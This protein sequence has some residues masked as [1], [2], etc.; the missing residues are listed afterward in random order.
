MS[1]RMRATFGSGGSYSAVAFGAVLITGITACRLGGPADELTINSA[2]GPTPDGGSSSGST[3]GGDSDGTT[4][5]SDTGSSSSG[6]TTGTSS[7]TGGVS[8]D[9][10]ADATLGDTGTHDPPDAGVI[11]PGPCVPPGAAP[12]VCDPVCNT[13]CSSLTRCDIADTANTGRCIGMWIS[14]EGEYCLK[15]TTTNPCAPKLACDNSACIQMCYND[16]DCA[17]AIGKCC[18]KTLETGGGPSGF[19]GCGGCN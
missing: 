8:G 2:V 1:T 3:T 6:S 10:G 16:S 7:T 17:S 14:H 15:T 13:G 12:A 9:A 18:N 11:D 4:G 5:G 19:K